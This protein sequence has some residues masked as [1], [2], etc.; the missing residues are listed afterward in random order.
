MTEDH[1]RHGRAAANALE[2]RRPE[3]MDVLHEHIL[4]SMQRHVPELVLIASALAMA[5]MV[6]RA[7]GEPRFHQ[8]L[9]E[10][11][12]ALH[13]LGHPVHDLD[14]ATVLLRRGLVGFP[15]KRSDGRVPV[16]ARIHYGRGAHVSPSGL[17]VCLVT[18]SF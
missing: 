16:T 17:I 15:D 5:H 2:Y 11:R 10:L 13:V 14:H 18:R 1:V 3:R 7:D 8:A 4:A 9:G 12:I 6:V